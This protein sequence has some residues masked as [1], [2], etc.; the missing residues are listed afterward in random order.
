MHAKET[1]TQP[2]APPDGGARAWMV[3][4]GAFAAQVSVLS[5]EYSG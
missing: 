5:Q 3:T 1:P 4:V 2:G